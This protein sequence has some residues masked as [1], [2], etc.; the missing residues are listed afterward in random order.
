MARPDKQPHVVFSPKL[1]LALP[2]V[3]VLIA[4]WLVPTERRLLERQIVDKAWGRAIETLRKLPARERAKQ[5]RYYA[6]LEIQLECRLL[7]A[8]DP[9][10]L[11]NLLVRACELAE[12]FQFD[13][14]FLAEI[15]ALLDPVRDPQAAYQSISP[16]LAKLPPARSAPL[17][18]AL[19]K[20]ALAAAQPV[21]AMQIHAAHWQASPTDAD[22]YI[23]RGAVN[24]ELKKFQAAR[25]DFERYLA[26]VP[27]ARDRD[28]VEQQIAIIDRR[29]SRS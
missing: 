6:L 15:T 5:A 25:A 24:V 22:S 10:A 21:L 8:D 3:C 9:V 7:A 20:K 16:V 4:L 18:E 29:L 19:V 12:P 2:V 14:D 26:L 13:S 17:Y 1:L 11:R 23:L 27:D 28:R